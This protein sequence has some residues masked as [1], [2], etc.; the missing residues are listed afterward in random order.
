MTNST[1]AN[2]TYK[3]YH[4]I[5]LQDL[6]MNIMKYIAKIADGFLLDF[7]DDDEYEG[8]M[9]PDL[10]LIAECVNDE[11]GT[12]FNDDDIFDL[13]EGYAPNKYFRDID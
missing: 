1:C 12:D 6:D 5:K 13:L 9:N 4:G 8:L 3:I 7:D 2:T 10:Q 11:F